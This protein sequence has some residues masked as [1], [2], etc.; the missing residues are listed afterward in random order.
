MESRLAFDIRCESAEIVAKNVE[1]I[2]LAANLAEDS[3]SFAPEIIRNGRESLQGELA[4]D[5]EL[6]Q[7]RTCFRRVR[8][9]SIPVGESG[10]SSPD[11]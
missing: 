2:T 7:I 11:R 3:F 10:E 6:R 1:T 8:S 9:F 4:P 5:A